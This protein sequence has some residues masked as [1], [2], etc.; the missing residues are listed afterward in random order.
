M[1]ETMNTFRN[2]LLCGIDEKTADFLINW[3]KSIGFFEAPASISHHG[4]ETGGLLDHSICMTQCLLDLTESMR[5]EWKDPRSPY[6]VGLFHDVCKAD[7]Y[8]HSKIKIYA[9]DK[10]T[11]M[12]SDEW[13]YNNACLL[14]GHG[15]KS[16]I[17]LQSKI[18]LTDEEIMCIRWHMGAYEGKEVWNN[19]GQAITKYPNV[20]FTHTADMM[21]ARILGV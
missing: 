7:N 3:A 2:M 9:G 15:E 8:V 16:V 17:M 19:L 10:E 20:L 6:L 1:K 11:E 14:T 4:N 5:L 21:A 18:N 13:E 12:D